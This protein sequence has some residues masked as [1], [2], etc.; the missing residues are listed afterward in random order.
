MTRRLLILVTVPAALWSSP[1]WAVDKAQCFDAAS[2]GQTLR[3]AH[4][5]L[6]AR[7][8]LRICA[9]Q[10]CPAQ[11]QK[12]CSSWLDAVE[13]GLPTVVISAKDG[14]G[15][16]LIDV[17]VTVDGQP[18][19]AKVTGD[20]IAIDPGSHTFHFQTADGTGSDQQVLV[21]E[22][23]KNQTVD[24]TFATPA[25]P[26]APAAPATPA[27]TAPGLPQVPPAA[28]TA[29]GQGSAWKTVGWIAGGVGVVALGVGSVFGAM[30]ISDKNNAHCDATNACDA[31][32]LSSA[33]SASTVSTIG[34]IAGG[35]L[36]AGGLTLVLVA[37]K[38]S[39]P[40]DAVG[41]LRVAPL[42]GPGQ[43]GAALTGSW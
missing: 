21:R 23:V 39:H 34:V 29:P 30:A 6:Q 40:P 27:S 25:A 42:V 4:K 12:D 19:A 38:A 35:V 28:D 10:S 16:D 17:A 37:P 5:L 14:S 24:V 31:G 2:Q 15:K 41:L 11:V 7:D 33:R 3:D 26:G 13:Q 18:F 20:A 8:Q 1:A 36:V 22:G 9:S 32:P 43:A